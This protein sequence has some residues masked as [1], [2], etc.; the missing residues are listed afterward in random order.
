MAEVFYT[1]NATRGSF[2]VN[3]LWTCMI[4]DVAVV[5]YNGE[6]YTLNWNPFRSMYEGRVD[7]FDG[8]MV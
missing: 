5:E 7:G 3:V 4:D 8:Y 6:Q 2:V 1:R